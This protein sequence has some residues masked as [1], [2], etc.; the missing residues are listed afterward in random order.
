[1]HTINDGERNMEIFENDIEL[2]LKLFCEENDVKDIRAASQSVWNAA[3]MYIRKHVF[4]TTKTLKT[5]KPLEGYVNNNATTGSIRHLNKSSCGRFDIDLVDSICDYYIYLCC[6]YDK[7]ISIMGFCKLTGIQQ[8]TIYE[9]GNN[10][11][12]LSTAG[13]YVYEKLI[14]E[15]EGSWVAKLESM[16]HP[17]AVAILLNKHYG[18]NL[19][20]VTKEVSTRRAL[21]ASQLPTLG[22]QNQE[23]TQYIVT[24]DSADTR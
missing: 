21:T 22:M 10:V 3:L 24:S 11:N 18:Y 2:Y 16:K 14:C 19:P 5:S 7:A 8:E 13:H 6:V 15:R 1:M 17:T 23:E 12:K 20:G 4:P 9:W